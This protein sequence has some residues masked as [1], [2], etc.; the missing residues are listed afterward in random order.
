MNYLI[1]CGPGIGDFILILPMA[2][3]IRK[4]DPEAHIC[5]IMTSDRNRIE[6]TRQLMDF[7]T[8]IDHLDYYSAHEYKHMLSFLSHLGFHKYDYGFVLQ[9]TDNT[10]P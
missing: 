2:Y 8:A 10:K 4:N 7:Q 9:Y 1:Y 5:A 3:A 6:I